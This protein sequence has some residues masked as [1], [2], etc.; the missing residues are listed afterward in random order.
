MDQIHDRLFFHRIQAHLFGLLPHQRI[1]SL[2]TV[3][4]LAVKNSILDIFLQL[5]DSVARLYT[6]ELHDIIS[7]YRILEIAHGIL[8]LN[9]DELPLD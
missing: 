4:D 1:G 5:T 8:F 2:E 6:E 7:S 9:L 3:L